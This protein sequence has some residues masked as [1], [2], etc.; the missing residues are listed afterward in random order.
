MKSDD[1]SR[2]RPSQDQSGPIRPMVVPPKPSWIPL[3]LRILWL[4]LLILTLVPLVPIELGWLSPFDQVVSTLPDVLYFQ[5]GALGLTAG[6]VPY[7]PGFMTAPY[8]GVTYLYPPLTLLLTVPPL[9]AG[10]RYLSAFSMEML[11]LALAGTY[12]LARATWRQGERQ[13]LGLAV[14]VLMFCLGPLLI[15]RVDAVLG[16]LVAGS[17]LSLIRGRQ[18]LA[19][20]MV[21][22]AVLVKETAVLAAVPIVLFCLFPDQDRSVS[23]QRRIRKVGWGLVPA[24]LIFALFAVWSRGGEVT[25]M[26]ASVRRGVEIESLPASIAILLSHLSPIH[27]YQGH[28][29]SEQFAGSDVGL[30]ALAVSLLG[31]SVVAVGALWFAVRRQRPAT[32]I[33]F[34]VA[35]GLCSTPVLSPQYLLE[36]FPLL[37]V[38]A[39]LELPRQ[40]ASWLLALGLTAAL[41]TQIEYPYLFDSLIHLQPVG[42]ALILAR[43]V[44]LLLIAVALGHSAAQKQVPSGAQVMTLFTRG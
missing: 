28:L 7:A 27:A 39:Y 24:L 19:V 17:A 3:L 34:C 1:G 5:H 15:T 41:L 33:A 35:V 31:A 42:I 30:V 40:R 32:S 37:V 9:L 36:L 10:S 8:H 14:L 13:P 29:R 11:A 23:L 18:A 44:T 12:L 6:H 43:N 21:G 20:A 22:L 38:A 26:L 16:L 4:P 2:Q 25:S